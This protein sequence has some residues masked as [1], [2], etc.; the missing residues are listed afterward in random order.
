MSP[1]KYRVNILGAGVSGLTTALV[2]L[3]SNHY[4]VQIIATH[5]PNELAL[6]YTS[7]WYN[8]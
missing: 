3:Q 2:L 8:S 7:P 6:D 5:L 4:S 1:S